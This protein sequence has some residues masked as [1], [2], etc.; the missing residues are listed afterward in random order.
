MRVWLI[1]NPASGSVKGAG[2]GTGESALDGPAA[3]AGLF[4]AGSSTFP[5]DP[6]PGPRQLAAAKVEMVVLFAGD[7]TINAAIRAL[8]GWDGRIL[9]LPGGTM[10]LLARRL[11]GPADPATILTR[12]TAMPA[13][14]LIPLPYVEAG[15]H[16]AFVAMIAGPPSTW[17]HAREAVRK[18]RLTAAWRAV[19]LAWARSFAGGVRLRGG[20]HG[21]RLRALVFIPD[22]RDMEVAAIDLNGW[23]EA[24][25]LGAEWLGGAWRASPAIALSRHDLA[26]VEGG[27]SV[28]LLFDGETAKLPAPL[29]VRH[30]TSRL[31]F[32]RTIDPSAGDRAA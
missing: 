12:A 21:G 24:L 27:R 25:R 7:G 2:S 5:R 31:R 18:G 10:N 11:H 19:R 3:R 26:T 28:H 20:R 22:E 9:I 23:L 29:R 13:P 4:I 30:G 15:P 32:L 6:L 17:A 14:D 16:R 1:V 8:E